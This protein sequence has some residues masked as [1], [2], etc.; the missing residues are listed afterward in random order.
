MLERE[1]ARLWAQLAFL[2][3]TSDGQGVTSVKA[4]DRQ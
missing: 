4:K 1:T 3:V 2:D